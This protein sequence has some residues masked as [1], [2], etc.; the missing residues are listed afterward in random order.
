MNSSILQAASGQQKFR[1]RLIRCSN[2]RNFCL[3]N[4]KSVTIF[5]VNCEQRKFFFIVPTIFCRNT[6]NYETEICSEQLQLDLHTYL[7]GGELFLR[8]CST[9]MIRLYIYRPACIQQPW[10]TM[11]TPRTMTRSSVQVQFCLYSLCCFGLKSFKILLITNLTRQ[12]TTYRTT[13]RTRA[14]TPRTSKQYSCHQARWRLGGCKWSAPNCKMWLIQKAAV[15]RALSGRCRMI[16][17]A[18]WVVSLQ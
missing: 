15:S 2:S 12:Y 13:K 10:I 16:R 9:H 17:P 18:L 11:S 3:R 6:G 14:M 4:V 8:L 5:R 1:W 7:G